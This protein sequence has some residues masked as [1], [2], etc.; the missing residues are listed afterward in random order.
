MADNNPQPTTPSTRTRSN[1]LLVLL[2]AVIVVAILSAWYFTNLKSNSSGTLTSNWS[3]YKSDK[4]K[5]KFSYP[6]EWDQPN[7]TELPGDTG[8][9]YSVHFGSSKP[10]TAVAS[11]SRA[12]SISF[13]SQDL[14]RKICAPN[15]PSSC[16]S[17]KAFTESNVK[18]SIANN[19]T[20][21]TTY[22]EDSTG[23]VTQGPADTDL[24]LTVQQVIS[25]PSV[26]ASAARVQYTISKAPTNC[27]KNKF[28]PDN[29]TDCITKS[30]YDTVIKVLDS[31]QSF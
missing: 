18:K 25:L 5:I 9:S 2:L 10:K 28:S 17:T 7:I 3:E 6:T 1:I 8:K 16:A 27:T 20:A 30:T 21:F 29:L 22:D 31:L 15:D 13:E 24:T 23:T 11:P 14:T 26:K 19:K 4:Y 12:V